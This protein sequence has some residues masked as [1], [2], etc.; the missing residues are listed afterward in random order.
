VREKDIST[1]DEQTPLLQDDVEDGTNVSRPTLEAHHS[2]FYDSSFSRIHYA[3]DAAKDG[4][5]NETSHKDINKDPITGKLWGQT[6]LQ[7][8]ATLYF[9]LPQLFLICYMLR[10]NY[11]IATVYDQ[12]LY[13]TNDGDLA[14]KVT[15]AFVILLPLGGVFSIPFIGYLLDQRS[16][17]TAFGAL[18]LLG[19]GYGVLCMTGSAVAQIVGILMFTIMRPLM[20]V[21][22]TPL[23]KVK[24][25]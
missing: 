25:M 21:R 19:L 8:I 22:R 2:S 11:E 18:L 3:I 23:L 24:L 20:Y 1:A 7:Q 13:Y 17:F 10:I 16:S 5:Y 4:T 6:A 9:W 14:Q 15:D 12:V